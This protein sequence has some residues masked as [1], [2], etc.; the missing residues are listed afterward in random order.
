[1][2]MRKIWTLLTSLLLGFCSTL[3]VKTTSYSLSSSAET[4]KSNQATE[5]LCD[6]DA[7]EVTDVD[8][9][10]KVTI[11][12]ATKTDHSQSFTVRF[13][14]EE[15]END[16]ILGY[17]SDDEDGLHYPLVAT[18]ELKNKLTEETMKVEEEIS[19]I[20]ETN[21]FDGIGPGMGTTSLTYNFDFVYSADYEFVDG[22][23]VVYNIYGDKEDTDGSIT[24]N[25]E[26]SYKCAISNKASDTVDVQPYFSA[27]LESVDTFGDYVTFNVKYQN[28]TDELYQIKKSSAYKKN[29]DDIE[30]GSAAIQSSITNVQTAYFRLEYN[31][32]NIMEYNINDYSISSTQTIPMG[33][34]VA[35]YMIKGI[36]L[37]NLK[38]FSLRGVSLTIQ[39]YS[40]FSDGVTKAKPN[41]SLVARVGCVYF[42]NENDDVTK[43]H[44]TNVILVVVIAVLIYL[45]VLAGLIAAFYFY[46]KNKYKN[47]EFR[48]VDNRRFFKTATI[49]YVGGLDLLLAILFIIFRANG[50]NNTYTTFNPLDNFIVVTCIL[51]IFFI[52]YFVKYFITFFKDR[53]SRK[54]SEKLK[55]NDSVDNDG[56]K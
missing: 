49:A 38:S 56:T 42:T 2:K 35:C 6:P 25:K 13:K 41:T 52:G 36:S 16:Y 30:S 45:I 43:V 11:T 47:D 3:G 9:E 17:N 18:Y 33:E 20:S 44:T 21:A 29:K 15:S 12:N 32:G 54:E 46:Q 37:E 5:S 48:R 7:V 22:S 1:M 23:L 10:F 34:S 55:L 39:V 40:V 4:K 50:F 19:R 28:T 51:L 31:D 27:S 24:I 26:E 8:E 14:A 53:K